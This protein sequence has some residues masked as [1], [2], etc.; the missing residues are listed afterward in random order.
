MNC[1]KVSVIIPVHNV[2]RYLR[3]C[4]DSAVNQTLRDIEIIC[5]DDGSTDRSG[6]ILTQYARRDD[7]LRVITQECAGV[8]VA[9]NRGMEEARGEYIFFLDS[10]DCILPHAMEQL[11]DLARKEQLDVLM[12]AA[13]K[14]FDSEWDQRNRDSAGAY[15]REPEL[16]TNRVVQGWELM[17]LHTRHGK[18]KGLVWL[19]LYSRAFLEQEGLRFL[20]GIIHEDEL[21][22]T[23]AAWKARRAYCIPDVLYRH[24]VRNGSIMTGR[25]LEQYF[26]NYFVVFVQ[27]LRTY[28][29]AGVSEKTEGL[30]R[31]I[32]AMHWGTKNAYK[33][34]TPEQRS[35]LL[36]GEL[37]AP[38]RP[39]FE[40]MD[41][42]LLNEGQP[43]RPAAQEKS[44][45][46]PKVSVI[47]P[48]Y[49]V[50]EYLHQCLDSVLNQTLR[51]IEVICV[52]DGSTDRSP[53]ILRE[54]EAKDPRV[55]VLYQN[56]LFAGVAR[57]AGMDVAR[58]KY[59]VFLDSDDFFEPQLL[60]LQY[61]QCEKHQAD[62]SICGAD[63]YRNQTGEFVP[64][65]WALPRYLIQKLPGSRTELTDCVFQLSNL[66][67]W[68][69][70]FSAEFVKR[71][72]LRFQ[73]LPRAND[74]LFC[75]SA[76][77][78]AERIT[79]VDR[80]LVHYRRGTG[81]NLQAG[82]SQTP[83]MFCRALRAV[84]NRL[85]AEGIY[86]DVRGSFVR[87]VMS[88]V[89][90]T[91]DTLEGNEQSYQ[92]L[93]HAMKAGFAD[94]FD[95]YWGIENDKVNINQAQEF[96]RRMV[97][98]EQTRFCPDD[99]PVADRVFFV[100]HG[101]AWSEDGEAP[102]V[103]LIIPLY[104]VER[105]LRQCLDSAVN[106]TL[107]EIEIIC[108]NDGST[109]ESLHILLE[110]QEK[111]PRITVVS[112]KNAGMSVAR[113][114]GTALA[115]GKYIYYL[116]S[117]D[118]LAPD[119]MET[120]YNICEEKM[121]DVLFFDYFRF[122]DDGSS[123]APIDRKGYEDVCDGVSFLRAMRDNGD[124]IVTV[125]TQLLRRD[126]LKEN[127]IDF[128]DGILHEDNL[129]TFYVLMNAKRVSHL[130]KQLY[131]HRLRANSVMRSPQNHNN[132]IGYFISMQE[133][134]LYGLSL[135][136]DDARRVEALR[137]FRTMQWNS[138]DIYEKISPEKREKIK[139]ENPLSQL[140]FDAMVA[141]AGQPG[142]KML[143]GNV[144]RMTKEEL[145]RQL[146][147]Y[148]AHGGAVEREIIAIRSSASYKI[149]RL[150]TWGPRKVRGGIRCFR[151]NG[152][153]YT[154]QRILE[155]L[156]L[157][158]G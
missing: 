32:K 17:N 88:Q 84:K 123:G 136:E 89:V 52:D 60:K 12:F 79:A 9:R 103:S 107:R 42:P 150:L 142:K 117:D 135:Q 118:Y 122:Y 5:V 33:Q 29:D 4:L 120:L 68:T 85:S 151:D 10:D 40:V 138:R 141:P 23:L 20:N 47:I 109:D 53:E 157:K 50:E 69:K 147:A 65:D 61:D 133:I 27:M 158:R 28:T 41:Y 124:Y 72:G 7:R 113:N 93:I 97:E 75:M 55:K 126:F 62:I 56:N 8:S 153:K 143:Q 155:R 152:M 98:A 125:W 110:Y 105:Y 74:V 71:H 36:E 100:R 31:R 112:G 1:P 16:T 134:L 131:Y 104:N 51:D 70:M 77:A 54:Y 132:V 94:E 22:T 21:F 119:A 139:F 15:E 106:Q 102:L 156:H 6:E 38:Y 14:F 90:Y 57:N 101:Q 82:N 121:L 144:G 3:E 92:I 18:F 19:H 58:G 59:Y 145:E 13:E 39:L 129:F 64:M 115:K 11:Y 137:M 111:D 91:L 83:L 43:V 63:V 108:V 146:R 86:E 130:N 66:A 99:I 81:T 73:N 44:A 127:R 87:N 67:P 96:Q 48:V 25:T 149:G 140:L 24:R 116:D 45:E 148:A 49:N 37:F 46:Q 34:M 26:N 114:R 35:H 78:L 2:E 80:V 30:L 128:Y 154:V 76:M 95:L